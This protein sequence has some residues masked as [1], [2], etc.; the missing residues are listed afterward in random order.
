MVLGTEATIFVGIK[1]LS[2]L[3]IFKSVTRA[4]HAELLS[5]MLRL[6]K[7]RLGVIGPTKNPMLARGCSMIVVE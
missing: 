4:R 2:R 7:T 3:S 6:A 5:A 1:A